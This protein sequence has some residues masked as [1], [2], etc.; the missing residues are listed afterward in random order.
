MSR[1][2]RPGSRLVRWEGAPYG[3]KTALREEGRAPGL[4]M[5]A[6]LYAVRSSTD[7]E[8]ASG[9]AGEPQAEV[10][11]NRLFN[12]GSLF[13]RRLRCMSICREGLGM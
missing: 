12:P 6:S 10:V 5:P 3:P 13:A 1:Q 4:L 8:R 2:R 9:G 11:G 7:A